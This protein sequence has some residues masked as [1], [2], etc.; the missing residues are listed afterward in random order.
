MRAMAANVARH[1]QFSTAVLHSTHGT[2]ASHWISRALARNTAK[3]N[4]DQ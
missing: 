1:L 4:S 3:A 2:A